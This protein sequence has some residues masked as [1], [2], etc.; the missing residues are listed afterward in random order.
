MPQGAKNQGIKK[1]ATCERSPSKVQLNL[2][3]RL[4][5]SANAANAL[6]FH[7]LHTLVTKIYLEDFKS[8]QARL[9]HAKYSPLGKFRPPQVGRK[10]RQYSRRPRQQNDEADE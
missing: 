1:W 2:L 9:Q 4:Q 10:R 5:V 6:A 3:P 7:S 8:R